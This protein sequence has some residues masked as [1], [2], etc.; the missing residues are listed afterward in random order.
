[1]KPA[2]S[3]DSLELIHIHP[4]SIAFMGLVYN[5]AMM[6][7]SINLQLL[8]AVIFL[9]Y[10]ANLFAFPAAFAG[11]IFGPRTVGRVSGLLWTL[12][13]PV[14]FVLTP[15]LHLTLTKFGGSFRPLL[16]FQIAS[17][18]PVVILTIILQSTSKQRGITASPKLAPLR[19]RDSMHSTEGAEGQ[20]IIRGVSMN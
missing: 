5:I 15:A 19:K 20:F 4:D 1:M 18:V 11:R 7:G 2:F 17:L 12:T 10:R 3:H 16:V 6:S 14:Q 13:C 8:T 9:V